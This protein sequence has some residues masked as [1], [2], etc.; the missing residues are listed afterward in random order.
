MQIHE[1]NV[2]NKELR[3]SF[4]TYFAV[5]EFLMRNSVITLSIF[6][7]QAFSVFILCF[8]LWQKSSVHSSERVKGNSIFIN[9]L[10][11]PLNTYFLIC[12]GMETFADSIFLTCPLRI[13]QNKYKFSVAIES[14]VIEWNSD[15]MVCMFMYSRTVQFLFRRYKSQRRKLCTEVFTERLAS[16]IA[17]CWVSIRYWELL[18][19]LVTETVQ[20]NRAV[21]GEQNM[22]KIKWAALRVQG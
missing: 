10:Y 22:T 13:L 21:F 9:T 19:K 4:P 12:P 18:E 20:I 15:I 3:H 8:S 6:C 1:L 14:S 16:D 5:I 2:M 11:Q 17:S 7:R